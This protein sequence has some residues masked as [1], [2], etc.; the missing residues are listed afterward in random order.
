MGWNGTAVAM[1]ETQPRSKSGFYFTPSLQHLLAEKGMV[2]S[3]GYAPAPKCSPSRCAI[4]T[5]QTTARNGFT[6]TGN[7]FD[8]GKRLIPASNNNSI[9]PNDITLAEWLKNSGKNYRTAHYGKWHLGSDGTSAHGFD[10]GD[11]NTTNDDGNNGGGAQPDP[12]NIFALT[13]KAMNFISDAETDGVPFYIQLSHYAVHAAIEAKQETIDLYNDSNQRPA[14]PNNLHTDPEFAA[15]TEDTDTGIG[16]LLEHITSLGLDENTY[17]IFMADNGAS[18]GLSDNFPLKRGK[19]FLTEGG[20]RVPFM[21]K[22]PNIPANTYSTVP[23][24]GYDIFPTFA[25]LTGATTALPT[26]DGVDISPAFTGGSIFRPDPLYF[27]SPHYTGNAK[28]PGSVAVYENFKLEVNYDSGDFILYDLDADIGEETDVTATYPEIAADLKLKLRDYLQEVEANMPSLDP[29]H[30]DF[31]GVAADVDQ[32]GLND[33][34]EIT[35]LLTFELSG[36]DDPDGDGVNNLAEQTAGTDPLV[37][38]A[39]SYVA[40]CY[41]VHSVEEKTV[42]KNED[43]NGSEEIQSARIYDGN[44]TVNYSAGDEIT[45]LTGFSVAAGSSFTAKIGPCSPQDPFM[46]GNAIGRSNSDNNINVLNNSTTAPKGNSPMLTL[47]PNPSNGLVHLSINDFSITNPIKQI[48]VL[49]TTGKVLFLTN[50][51]K[52]QLDLSAYNRGVY[53]V[54]VFLNDEVITERVVLQ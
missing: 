15:M 51:M 33:V 48:R 45:L 34:W 13:T 8:T 30:V 17:V 10:F 12:K 3:Q 54:Q 7:G 5:G 40:P 27:H 46:G 47:F 20:I 39:D 28:A 22:G 1:S 31:S 23:V 38:P 44:V 52:D 11:G 42:V 35:E 26:L 4:L 2:F 36:A 43:F 6:E 24:V 25:A 9:D 21:I 32:D 14:D 49:N 29:T 53:F 16:Q 37:N 50:N 41:L 18:R 19:A